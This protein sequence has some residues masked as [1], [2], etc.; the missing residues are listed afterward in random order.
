MGRF[1]RESTIKT[2]YE[3]QRK[4]VA[5]INER[6]AIGPRPMQLVVVS[7]VS[8]AVRAA[9]I[10][11]TIISRHFLLFISSAVFGSTFDRVARPAPYLG[12]RG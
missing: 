4:W 11:F 2:I 10:I 3:Q 12:L 6:N 1:A 7:A 8:A 5:Y 9:T